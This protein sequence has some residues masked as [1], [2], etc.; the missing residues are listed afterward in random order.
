MTTKVKIELVQENMPV[1]V[2]IIGS[3]DRVRYRQTLRR[4]GNAAEDYVHSGQ[5]L[6]VRE[7]TA[8]EAHD[9][10]LRE[11]AIKR[12]SAPEV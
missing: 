7:M 2:E 10:G 3:D 1:V 12:A 6:R 11:Q 4:I 9:D 8:Q 5:T